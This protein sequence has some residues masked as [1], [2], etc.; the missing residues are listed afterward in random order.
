MK[1]YDRIGYGMRGG[2][3]VFIDDVSS[4]LECGC[5]CVRCG[6]PLIAKKGRIRQHHFAHHVAAS[7]EGASETALHLLAKEL[8]ANAEAIEVPPY[9]V[10]ITRKARGDRLVRY[11]EKVARGGRV[12]IDD[13]SV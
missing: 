8:L 11:Q 5:T 12:R 6:Q 10:E 2:L 1:A 3:L 7:C 9:V 13:V 4:G